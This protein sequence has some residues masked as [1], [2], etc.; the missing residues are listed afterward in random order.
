MKKSTHVVSADGLPS[1]FSVHF[2]IGERNIT[3]RLQRNYHINIGFPI[4]VERYGKIIYQPINDTEDIAYY[5]DIKRVCSVMAQQAKRKHKHAF[6]FFGTVHIDTKVYLIQPP[7][8]THNTHSLTEI[9]KNSSNEEDIV[10]SLLKDNIIPSLGNPKPTVQP[11]N[12]RE[13]N[14]LYE[15]EILVVVDFSEYSFWRNRLSG[16]ASTLLDIEAKRNLRQYYAL[17]IHS[18]DLFYLSVSGRGFAIRLLLSGLH[19][20]DKISTSWWTESLK[21][22]ST[23]P[24]SI[25]AVVAI[26]HFQHWAGDH[27][28][29]LPGFDHAMLFTHYQLHD[30]QTSHRI[31]VGLAYRGGICGHQRTSLVQNNLD[32]YTSLT[33]AHEIGHNLGAYH[34]GEEN[35]CLKSDGYI[36]ASSSPYYINKTVNVRFWKFSNCS[37]DYFDAFIQRLNRDHTNCMTTRSTN[38][39]TSDLTDSANE[40]FGQVYAP[41]EQCQFL[42]GPESKMCRGFY[43]GDYTLICKKIILPDRQHTLS[44]IN[45][46]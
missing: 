37:L 3:L 44:E 38:Y 29:E 43:L 35:M 25:D 39:T 1:R 32:I 12:S 13:T 10:Q 27:E 16:N 19:V 34:D 18:T 6:E 11:R 33:A 23:S 31:I 22:D 14:R 20:S 30:F 2:S 36:M 17:L 40:I 46:I 8:D 45:T 15:V 5:H 24:A 26:E 9:Q 21:N 28:M 41:D 7:D 4:T 42:L